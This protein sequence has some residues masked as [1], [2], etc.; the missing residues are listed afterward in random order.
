ME[1]NGDR[2]HEQYAAKDAISDRGQELRGGERC[3]EP[4]RR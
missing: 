4:E 2:E 3:V 1:N